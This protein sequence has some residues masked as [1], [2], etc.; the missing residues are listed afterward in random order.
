M[1]CSPLFEI[2][3]APHFSQPK[4]KH[5]DD[6]DKASI[7]HLISSPT[8][9]WL[10]LSHCIYRLVISLSTL[11]P[12]GLCTYSLGLQLT[13]FICPHLPFLTSRLCQKLHYL[14]TLFMMTILP[15]QFL[16]SSAAL[17]F[18]PQNLY[19]YLMLLS[20]CLPHV[21]SLKMKIIFYSIALYMA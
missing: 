4:R 16:F 3:Q 1:R 15:S 14:A 11:L 10:T 18:P 5:P 20:G 7:I 12:P 9:S 19:H 13:S 17:F 8:V 2:D 6:S 21:C